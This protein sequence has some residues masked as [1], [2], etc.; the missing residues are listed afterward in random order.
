[1]TV[2]GRVWASNRWVVLPTKRS[3]WS[4]SGR[5]MLRQL[6]AG[7]GMDFTMVSKVV[8]ID[9]NRHRTPPFRSRLFFYYNDKRCTSYCPRSDRPL[10]LQRLYVHLKPSFI[11]PVDERLA[12]TCRRIDPSLQASV[13]FEDRQRSLRKKQPCD[14]EQLAKNTLP[15]PRSGSP[16]YDSTC[17]PCR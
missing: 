2:P 11:S 1:M 17:F 15:A 9:P 6:S 3:R 4:V 14:C 7:I 10:T 5:P 13:I 16:T 8:G 12:Q